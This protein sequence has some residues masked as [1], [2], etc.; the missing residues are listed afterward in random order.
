MAAR[1]DLVGE[2]NYSVEVSAELHTGYVD[3][4]K[5]KVEGFDRFPRFS[6]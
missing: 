6:I 5:V 3:A 2:A 4:C 1:D